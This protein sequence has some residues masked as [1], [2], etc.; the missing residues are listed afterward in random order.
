[1]AASTNLIDLL[2]VSPGDL[3]YYLAVFIIAQAALFMALGARSR[4][5]ALRAPSVYVI[6]HGGVVIAWGLLLLAALF[7]LVTSTVPNAILPP[8]DRLV[9]VLVIAMLAWAFIT[10]DDERIGR[11]GNIVIL[12]M[13][14]WI[15]VGFVVTGIEWSDQ[16]MRMPFNQFGYATTWAIIAVVICLTGLAACVTQFRSITD[17]PL[18][19]VFFGVLLLGF[20]AA[21]VNMNGGAMPGDYAGVTRWAFLAAVLLALGIVYRMVVGVMD[22]GQAAPAAP[23]RAGTA[24]LASASPS[25]PGMQD[26]P[27]TQLPVTPV[28]ERE[29]AQ[30]MKA[31]GIMLEKASP[32]AIPERIVQAAVNT[33][34]ADMGALLRI[35]GGGYVDIAAGFDRTMNRPIRPNAINLAQQP[36]MADAIERRVQRSLLKEKQPEE[37]AELYSRMDIDTIGPAYFQ[38]LVSENELLAV[39]VIGL[40]YSERELGATDQELLRGIAIIAANLLSLSYASRSAQLEA[41]A[42]AIEA[43]AQGVPLE[44]VTDGS[45]LTKWNEMRGELEAARDQINQLSM[46][47]MSLRIELDDERTRVRDVLS[48]TTE[49][50]SVSQR[51]LTLNEAQQR[52]IDERDRLAARLREAEMAMASASADEGGSVLASMVALLRQ[53]K[54][55]LLA[56]RDRM[57]REIAELRRIQGAESPGAER[58]AS[59]LAQDQAQLERERDDLTARLADME[60]R[61]RDMG[62]AVGDEGLSGVVA[63]VFDQQIALQAQ[64]EAVKRERDALLSGGDDVIQRQVERER[65]VQALQ[66]EIANLASD[67]EAVTKSRD[68]LKAERDEL[69][70][71]QESMRSLQARVLAENAAYEQELI[72]AH[73]EIEDVRAE[74]Q[75]I[76]NER[77]SLAQERDLL[78][79]ERQG[80]ESARDQLMARI[81]GDRSRLQQLG[82]DGVGALTKMIDELTA[83][84][85]AVERELNETRGKLAAV[86][87]RLEMAEIRAA[88]VQPEVIYRSDNPDALIGMIQELR[89]PMTSI[90]GY[91][92]LLLNESAGILGEMQRKFM[93]RVSANVNRLSS[94]MDDLIQLSYLDAGK[95]RLKPQLV[96]AVEVLEDAISNASAPLREKGLT[97][98]LELDDDAPVV[99]ADRDALLQVIGQLLT[100]AYLASPTGTQLHVRAKRHMMN[101]QVGGQVESYP[102]LLISFEDAGGGIALEDQSRVFARKYKAENPLIQGLGDTGV[103]L[104]IA[105]SLV[106]AHDGEI[107]VESK[108]G[109]GASFNFIL[110]AEPEQALE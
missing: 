109:R 107:W 106:E 68:R 100:N 6:A 17:A 37:T 104:A 101:R 29:S 92:D 25:L 105:K 80:L 103:G 87:N 83:Q 33:L 53:E 86:E 2:V 75:R 72:E 59:R 99:C 3:I 24:G 35:Q 19:M 51:I 78:L 62:V 89:T 31:L 21:L 79:A 66:N 85:A 23:V 1:V 110:P 93:Q 57:E 73:G 39:L 41:E 64:M 97:V 77:I 108:P 52:L 7:A 50:Q 20:G 95:F 65:I 28:P 45:A 76:A 63:S 4:R 34:K 74:L 13:L 96:N 48:D 81:E 90:V 14:A 60:A 82:A 16:F 102:V 10:A 18:K 46:Q 67:R 22:E 42:R 43:M 32:D 40:P 38:P 56:Q 98:N 12:I 15:A 8:T 54:D 26:V 27:R 9:H 61:L 84:R 49:T 30:L 70:R 71:K 55:D 5:K 11:I 47:V 36:T 69:L 44:D 58:V 88:T 94:M 91:V